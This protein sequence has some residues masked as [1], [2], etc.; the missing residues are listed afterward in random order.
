MTGGAFPGDR[1][2]AVEE[3]ANDNMAKVILQEFLQENAD[4]F[5]EWTMLDKNLREFTSV[6]R[7]QHIFF[8]EDPFPL[9]EVFYVKELRASRLH[10][11][12]LLDVRVREDSASCF[13]GKYAKGVLWPVVGG[14][15]QWRIEKP[16]S[17]LIT[18]TNPRPPKKHMTRELEASL[19]AAG[20]EKTQPVETLSNMTTNYYDTGFCS[21]HL[22]QF[23]RKQGASNNKK[24]RH[25]L[26]IETSQKKKVFL[27]WCTRC[28][29]WKN[30]LKFLYRPRLATAVTHCTHCQN[31]G[32]CSYPVRSSSSPKP[33][34]HSVP[35]NDCLP[36][37]CLEVSNDFE[38]SEEPLAVVSMMSN[39][40]EAF[41]QGQLQSEVEKGLLVGLLK[42]EKEEKVIGDALQALQDIVEGTTAPDQFSPEVAG[43]GRVC[44]YLLQEA[45]CPSSKSFDPGMP[46]VDQI[47]RKYPCAHQQPLQIAIKI[48]SHYLLAVCN[49]FKRN[50][51][52]L[53]LSLLKCKIEKE[54]RLRLFLRQWREGCLLFSFQITDGCFERSSIDM[55]RVVLLVDCMVHVSQSGHC[56]LL[57]KT[58]DVCKSVKESLLGV[59]QTNLVYDPSFSNFQRL[60]R[61]FPIAHAFMLCGVYKKPLQQWELALKDWRG[62]TPLHYAVLHMPEREAHMDLR[63]LVGDLLSIE[64]FSLFQRNNQGFTPLDLAAL[65][66]LELFDILLQNICSVSVRIAATSPLARKLVWSLKKVRETILAQLRA[67]AQGRLATTAGRALAVFDGHLKRLDRGTEAQFYDIRHSL[68]RHKDTLAHSD[69]LESSAENTGRQVFCRN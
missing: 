30:F 43:Q 49:T 34:P 1:M 15:P 59:S 26:C 57:W 42:L 9:L 68:H 21:K 20:T 66:N 17:H 10:K 69:L 64:L 31:C 51:I 14:T 58:P 38:A 27:K 55:Q 6:D 61:I 18:C 29:K 28:K 16:P 62:N 22:L 60:C 2:S 23:A 24:S 65:L 46:T 45:A 39:K 7:H 19:R 13:L 25:M 47:L 67:H 48:Q 32:T 63:N 52:Y 37:A 8:F 35:G 4:T 36:T 40:F 11:E 50:I 53:G 56:D 3:V 44:L 12:R 33:H 41:L 5:W 54:F